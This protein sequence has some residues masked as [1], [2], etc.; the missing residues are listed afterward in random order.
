MSD[1]GPDERPQHG[2]GDEGLEAYIHQVVSRCPLLND[3]QCETLA[4]LLGFAL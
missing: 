4:L 3:Q 1:S 2:H